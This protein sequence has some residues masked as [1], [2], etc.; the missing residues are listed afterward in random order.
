MLQS[1]LMGRVDRSPPRLEVLLQ[2]PGV[3]DRGGPA[4]AIDEK[5][6]KALLAGF[7]QALKGLAAARTEEGQRLAG[8]LLGQVE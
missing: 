5:V 4:E 6:E 7:S 2:V 1:E 8:V 3:L